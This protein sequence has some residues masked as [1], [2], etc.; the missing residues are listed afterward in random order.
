M[1][2]DNSDVANSYIVNSDNLINYPEYKLS[3]IRG[4]RVR[5]SDI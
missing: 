4:E 1:L 5:L 2:L 3:E